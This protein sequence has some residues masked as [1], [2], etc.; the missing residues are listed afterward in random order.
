MPFVEY[1]KVDPSGQ[2]LVV[3]AVIAPPEGLQEGVVHV[4]FVMVTLFGVKPVSI[5]VDVDV[6]ILSNVKLSIAIPSS[7]PVTSKSTHLKQN[8]VPAGIDKPEMVDMIIAESKTF[9]E[10]IATLGLLA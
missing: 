1:C 2:R 5:Q 9:P 6:V 4:L 8:I 7:D 3:G 10:A